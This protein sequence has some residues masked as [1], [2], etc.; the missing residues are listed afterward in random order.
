VARECTDTTTEH[1]Y[2]RFCEGRLIEVND[3]LDHI[4][5]KGILNKGNRILGDPL[6]QPNLLLAR[7]MVNAA[8]ED[9]AAVAVCSDINAMGS[10]SVEDELSIIG[11]KLVEALLNDMIAVQVLDEL[12]DAEAK[13]IDDELCLLWSRHKLNH[14]LQ[15]SSAMLVQGNS[16]HVLGSVLYENGPLLIVAILEQLLAEVIAKRIGHQLHDVLV[17]LEP[18]HVDLLRHAVLKLLL[19]VAA[20]VLILAELIDRAPNLLERQILVPAHS[21][22][23]LVS[24]AK[25]P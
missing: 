7:G 21:Y 1:S 20:A 24:K 22:L 3:V 12:H 25:Y 9:T 15:S 17:G 2:K 8:L 18:D 23:K 5:A 13:G 16:Y 14:F 11:T 19:E 6:D 4:V 10:D